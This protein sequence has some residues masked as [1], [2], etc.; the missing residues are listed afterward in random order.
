MSQG[1]V[2]SEKRKS[3]NST[4]SATDRGKETS[5]EEIKKVKE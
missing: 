3:S 2:D 1:E 4:K 5:E